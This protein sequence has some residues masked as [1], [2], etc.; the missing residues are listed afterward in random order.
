[1][2]GRI[3]KI[4]NDINNKIYIGKTYNSIN[5]RFNEHLRDSRKEK[6]KN[7]PLH[8]AIKKYGVKHF[9]VELLG[10]HEE[11]ILE[12]K[13]IE[14]I[15]KYNSYKNGYNATLGGDGSRYFKYS[16]KEVIGKYQE[17]GYVIDVAKYYKCTERTVRNILRS[18]DIKIKK[19]GVRSKKVAKLNKDTLEILE[20]F[21]S[22]S[23]AGR[24]L[25]N[26]RRGGKIGLACKN[27][28]KTAYGFRW[29]FI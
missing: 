12:K 2:K 6:C 5:Q 14:F 25:G 21:E 3:Y 16:D 17:L 23:E 15:E 29:K 4:T 13:E 18:N 9:F 28:E 1:M 26:V 27:Q 22:A 8:Y 11:G 19:G 10:E 24:K 7:Q 20:I